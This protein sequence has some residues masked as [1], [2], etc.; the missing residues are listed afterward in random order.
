MY[1]PYT[2]PN[3]SAVGA[4]GGPVFI[5]PGLNTSLRAASAL[6]PVNLTALNETVPGSE[7]STV[8]ATPSKTG[9]AMGRERGVGGAVAVGMVRGAML[10]A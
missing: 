6:A 1:V 7:T 4:G 3:M 8:P 10:F 2:A 9:K 5:G